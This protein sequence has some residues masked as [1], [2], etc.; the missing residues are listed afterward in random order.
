VTLGQA[1]LLLIEARQQDPDPGPPALA[2]RDNDA[3]SL[4]QY[5]ELVPAPE[6]ALNRHLVRL[7]TVA[8]EEHPDF[9]QDLSDN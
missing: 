5:L 3:V 8:V 1:V 9:A 7:R 4:A 2:E 6:A